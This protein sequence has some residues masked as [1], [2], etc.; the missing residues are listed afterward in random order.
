[1][2]LWAAEGAGSDTAL[3]CNNSAGITGYA[4]LMPN[5]RPEGSDA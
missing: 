5:A 3:I 4:H 1:M 2:C